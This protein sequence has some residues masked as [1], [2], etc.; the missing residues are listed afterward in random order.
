[1]HTAVFPVVILL[2]GLLVWHRASSKDGVPPVVAHVT[3]N[4]ASVEPDAGDTDALTAVA[5]VGPMIIGALTSETIEPLT[6]QPG[7][8]DPA[9]EYVQVA[10]APRGM[11]NHVP[12]EL[13]R[14]STDVTEP[15][16]EHVRVIEALPPVSGAEAGVADAVTPAGVAVSCIAT[17]VSSMFTSPYLIL[18]KPFSPQLVPQLFLTIQ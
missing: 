4:E 3:V 2:Y 8:Y 1:M 12:V 10:F 14:A 5:V 13:H 17:A 7:V 11:L 18:T 9:A 16:V 6:R 15:F